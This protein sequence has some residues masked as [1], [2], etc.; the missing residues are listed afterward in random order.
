MNLK[1]N[2]ASEIERIY[3][4]LAKY[5][6]VRRT[7]DGGN[8]KESV[9][10]I[11]LRKSSVSASKSDGESLA[12]EGECFLKEGHNSFFNKGENAREKSTCDTVQ[13]FENWFTFPM[14]ASRLGGIK[15]FSWFI[16]GNPAAFFLNQ[17]KSAV[18]NEDHSSSDIFVRTKEFVM[19]RGCFMDSPESA[20][21]VRKWTDHLAD[22]MC[23]FFVPA[24]GTRHSTSFSRGV[25]HWSKVKNAS[26]R[27]EVLPCS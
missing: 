20:L 26:G 16:L 1:R 23:N 9:L 21:Y 14:P 10:E 24:G 25:H 11:A 12:P 5:G 3:R 4:F 18:K 17:F 7:V 22:E 15:G 6:K 13:F 2:R 8:G 27:I 19:E